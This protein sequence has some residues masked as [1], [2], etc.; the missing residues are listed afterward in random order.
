MARCGDGKTEPFD[1]CKS[2]DFILCRVSIKENMEILKRTAERALVS[3]KDLRQEIDDSIHLQEESR[4]LIVFL[5]VLKSFRP[6][7]GADHA[8]S[9]FR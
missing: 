8:F 3:Y 9:D 4:I 7:L 2:C 5:T 1:F 6:L